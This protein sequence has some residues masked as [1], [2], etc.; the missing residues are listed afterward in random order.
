[1]L[2][3]IIFMDKQQQMDGEQNVQHTTKRTTTKRIKI[4]T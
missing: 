4:I 3:N 1:M 2:F